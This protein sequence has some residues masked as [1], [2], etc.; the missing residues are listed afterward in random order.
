MRGRRGFTLIE[1]L[2]AA[3]VLG[4]TASALFGLLSSSLFNLRKV[5]DLHRYELVAEDVMNRVL[6]S[7]TLAAPATAQGSIDDRG[8]QWAV[9][10]SP[11]APSSLETKPEQAVLR[12]DVVVSWPGRSS[13]QSLKVESLKVSNVAY[14]NYDLQTAIDGAYPR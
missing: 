2:V 1:V 3:S 12:I 8:G 13:Q 11:W 6:L 14:S 5:E 7:S 10:V 9:K 4:I